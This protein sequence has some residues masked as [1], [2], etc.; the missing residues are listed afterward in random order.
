MQH[1]HLITNN[2]KIVVEKNFHQLR[3]YHRIPFH[4]EIPKVLAKVFN[5]PDTAIASGKIIKDGDKTTLAKIKHGNIEL[6]I[7]RYNILSTRHAVLR[8]FRRSRA[9]RCWV[10]AHL[11]R[12]F[13]LDT[14]EPV[15]MIEQRQGSI[16]NQAYYVSRYRKGELGRD[17]ILKSTPQQLKQCIQ[18]LVNDLHQLHDRKITHGDLKDTNWLWDQNQNKWI[19]LDL[20]ATRQ[21]S[22]LRPFTVTWHRDMCRLLRNW[23]DHPDILEYAKQEIPWA[24][25]L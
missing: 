20:D 2:S 25:N 18:A 17:I 3:I 9:H 19:W 16:R 22:W 15:A 7:K 24:V 4:A 11:L 21:H 14:P 5:D 10:Y 12:E 6:V 1:S 23:E 13:G 8:S